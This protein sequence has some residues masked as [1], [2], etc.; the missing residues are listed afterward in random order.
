MSGVIGAVVPGESTENGL[1][2]RLNMES[3]METFQRKRQGA[4]D[5][6]GGGAK[7]RG[8]ENDGNVFNKK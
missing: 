1:T 3:N 2:L 6:W 7:G 8:A 4:S 5:H